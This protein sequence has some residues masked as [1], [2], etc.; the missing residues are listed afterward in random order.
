MRTLGVEEELLLV[1]PASGE[2]VSVATAVLQHGDGLDGEL[3]QQQVETGTSPREDLAAVDEDVRRWR[4]HADEAARAAGVRVA[5]LPT[6]PLP[7]T[8]RTSPQER[9]QRIADRFGLTQAE[10]LVCGCHVHVGV[11]SSEEA[12]A[13]VDRVRV[14][15]P[16]LTALSAN[17]PFWQGEDS[18]YASFRSQVWDRW[19]MAGPVEVLGSVPAYRALVEDL[20]ATGVML[21][22]AQL[23]LDVRLSARY[24]TVE[25]RVAD[26]CLRAEDTVLLAGLGRA[27]VET[28][29]REWRAGEPPAAVPAHLLRM[30]RWR[31][32]RSG[33]GE[34][35]LDP[36][37][38]RPRPAR[39]VVEQLFAHVRPALRDCGD[40]ADVR[41][42]L[43]D[44]LDRGTGADRQRRTFERTG[45]L[46]DV[47]LDAVELTV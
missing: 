13:V 7:V 19:P 10:Q 33:L 46:R 14:W 39:D 4:R 6:S 17:S 30:A 1:D 21:D 26:V 2:P 35:L 45:E 9:Y 43:D 23:Y 3:T 41:K 12:V 11:E 18:S 37:T 29:A 15:L 34:D 36:R 47:V 32:G 27:L 8:P 25:L 5:A 42:R 40:E 20:V 22:E 28:A 38:S 31:A 44:V 16:V 24:P